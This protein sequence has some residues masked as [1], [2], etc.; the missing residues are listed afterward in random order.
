MSALGGQRR[1]TLHVF[2]G[3]GWN[4][5]GNSYFEAT[6]GLAAMG[7]KPPRSPHISYGDSIRGMCGG[8][9]ISIAKSAA[10]G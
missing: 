7:S 9:A 8:P 5:G 6:L 1:P 3:I 10:L 2:P 4:I